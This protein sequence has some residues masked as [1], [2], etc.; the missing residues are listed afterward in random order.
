MEGIFHKQKELAGV[1]LEIERTY[2]LSWLMLNIEQEHV[3]LESVEL[4][5]CFSSKG[6]DSG[7]W[8]A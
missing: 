7:L 1:G 2:F 6:W 3:L 5:Q 4:D 8:R